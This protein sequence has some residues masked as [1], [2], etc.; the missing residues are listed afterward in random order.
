MNRNHGS[1]RNKNWSVNRRF[2]L[3]PSHRRP[4][5]LPTPDLTGR[6]LPP[7]PDLCRQRRPSRETWLPSLSLYKTWPADDRNRCAFRRRRRRRSSW[8]ASQAH[9]VRRTV[10]EVSKWAARPIMINGPTDSGPRRWL[11][12]QPKY[13]RR[14]S[15]SLFFFFL[16]S[17]KSA[18]GTVFLVRLG[19]VWQSHCPSGPYIFSRST[20]S[21]AY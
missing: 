11:S 13:G 12:E 20:A 6:R 8:S 9:R 21:K 1:S 18:I 15:A 10:C 3:P 14:K 17:R 19:L 2:S 16:R 7:E 4:A 5:W